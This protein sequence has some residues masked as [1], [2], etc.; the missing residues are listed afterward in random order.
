MPNNHFRIS[1]TIVIILVGAISFYLGF[2]HYDKQVPQSVYQVYLD[3]EVIGVV[4]NQEDLESYINLKEDAIKKKYGVKKVFMPNG[5]EIKRI[6][7]YNK[8]INT[9]EEVYQSIVK[10]KQF[11][12]KGTVI[13]IKKK[14]KKIYIY[15]LNKEIFDKAIE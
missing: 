5:V 7:T 14:D 13:T 11:T 4:N 10:K 6:T 8:N 12:I 15:T 2:I 9:N 1:Y 3:G